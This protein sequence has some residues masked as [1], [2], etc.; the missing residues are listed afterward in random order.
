M[1]S[2][3][4]QPLPDSQGRREGPAV[5]PGR[6]VTDIVSE[7]GTEPAVLSGKWYFASDGVRT[8]LLSSGV[9]LTSGG[10]G[11][12]GSFEER[13]FRGSVREKE[14]YLSEDPSLLY[15]FCPCENI[16]VKFSTKLL[17]LS[18]FM[19]RERERETTDGPLV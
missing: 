19:W 4:H 8:L 16:A 3:I 11:G 6:G 10:G 2:R 7:G 1:L 12:V 18:I 9:P 15:H 17:R 13:V 14:V 5:L